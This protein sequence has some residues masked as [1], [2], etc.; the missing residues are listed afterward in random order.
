[1]SRYHRPSN[2][3]VLCTLGALFTIFTGFSFTRYSTYYGDYLG[4]TALVSG[5]VTMIVLV[6]LQTIPQRRTLWGSIL[7]AV[8]V[9]YWAA[10]FAWFGPDFKGLIYGL[11]Y[12][13][14]GPVYT[15]VGGILALLAKPA[16]PREAVKE[17]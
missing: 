12:G 3:Y 16:V 2:V 4:T 15:L 10:L 5:L 6:M 1:M 13:L 8:S 17:G 9:S 14:S 7:V 11:I